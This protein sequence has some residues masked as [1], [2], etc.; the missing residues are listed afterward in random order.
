MVTLQSSLV[1]STDDTDPYLCRYSVPDAEDATP[2]DLV[3]LRWHGFASPK[4]VMQ[5]FITLLYVIRLLEKIIFY[6][7][8]LTDYYS[9]GRREIE[10]NVPAS[11]AWFALTA[12]A[13]G[14]DAVEGKDGYTIMTLPLT[15]TA[16]DSEG[17]QKK[18]TGPQ[19]R[20]HRP[21]VCWEYV[22]ASVLET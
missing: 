1:S 10:E 18:P 7:T 5:L 14:R 4:W 11:S 6:E 17:G 19:S 21:C 22:G 13:L 20:K 16:D 12:S 3:S 8:S 2:S 9:Y 15:E